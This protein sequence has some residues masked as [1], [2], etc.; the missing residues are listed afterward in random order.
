[1]SPHRP[2]T[3]PSP[4][5]RLVHIGKDYRPTRYEARGCNGTYQS[6]MQPPGEHDARV[7]SALIDSRPSRRPLVLAVGCAAMVAAL[8]PF[9]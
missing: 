9:L 2:P 5:A 4:S 3:M 6:L 1:M 7:Q 8:V